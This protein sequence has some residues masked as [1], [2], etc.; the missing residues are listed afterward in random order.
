V[1]W[2]PPPGVSVHVPDGTDP[3]AALARTT[4]LAVVAH[5]DDLELA[6]PGV[7]LACRDDPARWFTGVVCTDGAGSV[8][9]DG[10]DDPGQLVAVR[11]AEQRAAADLG[12][13]N[14]V[15]LLGRSSESV[16]SPAGSPDRVG[17]VD[18]LALLLATGGATTVHTHNPA[19]AHATHVAVATAVIGALRQLPVTA[20]PAQLLGWEGWRDLD[21]LPDELRVVDDLTGRET[22]AL[23]L[24]RCHP[25][26]L[27]P[28][29]YDLAAQGR[30]R[31]NATFANARKADTAT[32][33]SVGIDLTGA[34]D[35]HT[36]PTTFVLGAI[37]RFR[38]DVATGLGR[39]W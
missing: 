12:A 31:A 5:P 3:A 2:S 7:I 9:P 26:Q 39:W 13:M 32:E 19:D 4:D 38:S 36:D 15:V 17:F 29:R 11:A 21:W 27:G 14:A 20:R 25:S 35:D 23:D 33:A 34:L 10:V 6:M 24:A 18:A 28:K 22:A 1:V 16:R 8:L 37:D 30:R